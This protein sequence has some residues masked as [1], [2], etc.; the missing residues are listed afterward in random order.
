MQGARSAEA[1][2]RRPATRLIPF[3]RT[4]ARRKFIFFKKNLDKRLTDSY[5]ESGFGSPSSESVDVPWKDF[6]QT[7]LLFLIQVILLNPSLCV[8]I[9]PVTIYDVAKKAG[10][11]IGT[12]SRAI[13]GSAQITE[14]TKQR[15]MQV[16]ADLNYQPHSVAQSLARQKTNTIGCI[17]PFFTGYFSIELLRGIQRKT[18]DCQYDLILYSVD[19]MDKRDTFLERALQERRVDGI[20][21]VSLGI[22]D[23]LAEKFIAHKLPIVLLDSSHSAL[24]SIKV[25]NIEGAYAATL[26]LIDLGYERLA[27]I[28]GKTSSVPTKLRLQGYQRALSAR[29]LQYDEKYFVPCD[30]ALDNDGFNKES[31]YVAMQRLLA[32]SDGRPRAVFVSSDI[33]AI[34]AMQAIRERGLRIPD[35]VAIVAFDDIEL[36]DFVRLTTMKQPMV[37][38]GELAM[39]RL[40]KKIEDPDD[41]ILDKH[42]GTSLVIRDSCGAIH[43]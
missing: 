11:G 38:M 33:Q 20:L 19:I 4:T 30:F 14:K 35:D 1:T 5:Y 21:L 42:F 28:G 16:I 13:N 31:G 40:M 27:M 23:Q 12:V 10:V 22:S 37:Q 7:R 8:E 32:F 18:T 26:H 34:G 43:V 2:N 25:D 29:G 6:R 39:Q 41:T 36:A 3:S 15:V 24:D 9:V 17:I